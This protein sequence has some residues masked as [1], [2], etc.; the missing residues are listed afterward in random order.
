[1]VWEGYYR[2]E[3]L[4]GEK[5]KSVHGAPSSREVVWWGKEKQRPILK[6]DSRGKQGK[7]KRGQ[8][9]WGLRIT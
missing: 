7:K 2:V 6:T 3:R 1:V 4:R 9:N 8:K 5:E